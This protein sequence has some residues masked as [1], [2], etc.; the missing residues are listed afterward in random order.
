MQD[1]KEFLKARSGQNDLGNNEKTK[2]SKQ[3]LEKQKKTE[4]ADLGA[5]K[6]V[7]ESKVK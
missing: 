3:C 6:I 4:N 1:L 2:R 5:I 7:H